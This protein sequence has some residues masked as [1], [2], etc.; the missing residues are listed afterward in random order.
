[1]RAKLLYSHP[2]YLQIHWYQ[3]VLYDLY[4]VANLHR[5]REGFTEH[6]IKWCVGGMRR[7]RLVMTRNKRLPSL[8]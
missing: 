6:D 4:H 3:N 1:M 8:R 7:V 5:S 2:N